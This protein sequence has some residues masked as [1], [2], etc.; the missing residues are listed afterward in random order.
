MND[1]DIQC[2]NEIVADLRQPEDG[3]MPDGTFE[4]REASDN[5]LCKA[6][7]DDLARR[8]REDPWF[9]GSA[10][11]WIERQRALHSRGWLIPLTEREGLVPREVRGCGQTWQIEL[12]AVA[13][14]GHAVLSVIVTRDNEPAALGCRRYYVATFDP[15]KPLDV[16]MDEVEAHVLGKLKVREA[17]RDAMVADQLANDGPAVPL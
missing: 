16:S 1:A 8:L 10:H 12:L 2:I 11:P 14:G 15:K 3:M 9:K 7:A 4:S 5:Y 17:Q 13:P 6:V